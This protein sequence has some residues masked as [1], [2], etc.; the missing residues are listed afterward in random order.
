[1][2]LDKEEKEFI[3]ANQKILEQIFTKRIEELKN[4]IFS[5]A[6]SKEDI[7]SEIRFVQE[8]QAWLRTIGIIKGEK[9]KGRT[10]KEY[11]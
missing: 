5:P 7:D 1:M 4:N 11:E 6:F 2:I 8:Y 9:Q 3:E 10:N